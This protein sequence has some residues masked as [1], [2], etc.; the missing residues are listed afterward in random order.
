VGQSL[1]CLTLRQT[2]SFFASDVDP[3]VRDYVSSKFVSDGGDNLHKLELT[4]ESLIIPVIP[5]SC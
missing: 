1:L 3:N 4:T 5:S 2:A